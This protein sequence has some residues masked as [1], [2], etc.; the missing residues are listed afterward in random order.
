MWDRVEVGRQDSNT[1]FFTDLMYLGEMVSK[2]TVAALLAGIGDDTGRSR[3][4]HTADLVRADGIGEWSRVLDEILLGPSGQYLVPEARTEQRELTQKSG[5]GTWQYAAVAQLHACL[6]ALDPECDAL[7]AKV[8]GRRWVRDFAWLRNKTRGHGAPR[9]ELFNT[10][11]PPLE[12][13]LKQF[14]QHSLFQREWAYVH[15]NLS[16]KYRVT[17]LGDTDTTFEFLKTRSHSAAEHLPN[18][19]YVSLGRPL[20]VELA[21]STVDAADFFLANGGFNEKRFEMISYASGQTVFADSSPYMNPTTALPA[22]ETQGLGQLEA[23][24]HCFSNMPTPPADYVRREALE[25]DLL[26]SLRNDRHPVVTLLGR[27][28]IGKTS[29]ALAAAHQL[30]EE[31]RFEAIIWFSA[32]DLDLL[33][34]G[35][36]PVRAAVLSVD[37]IALEYVR[38][39]DPAE[40]KT[41]GFKAVDHLAATLTKPSFGP[42]LFV[43]DNFET[44]VHPSEL[45]KWLDTYIRLPNKIL[46]TTRHRDFRGDYHIDVHGMSEG[47]CDQLIDSVA[48]RRGIRN[49]LTREYREELFR[50]SEGHPYVVKILLGEVSKAR[51]LRKVE[52]IV[53]EADEIL[54]A[55][56]ERTYGTLSPAAQRVFLTLCNWR[57]TVP[58]MA[59][60]AVLLRSANERMAVSDATDELEQSSFIELIPSEAD[61]EIFVTTPLVASIFGKRKLAVSPMK[62]AIEIDTEIL[63]QFGAGQRADIKQGLAPRLERLIATIAKQVEENPKGLEQH[64]PL[65]E[66]IAR[67]QPSVWLDIAD[68]YV[69]SNAADAADRAKEAVRRHLERTT[70]QQAL[71]SWRRLADLC[72]QTGDVV[73]EVHALVESCELPGLPFYELSSAANRINGL[74]VE[75]RGAIDSEEKRVLIRRIADALEARTG[76]ADA[77]AFSRLAWLYLH[78][79]DDRRAVTLTKRGLMLDGN[80]D[81]CLRLAERLRI[82]M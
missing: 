45:F 14:L 17:K 79:K 40:A 58:R 61:G 13:S 74:L 47:E 10:L 12:E 42:T 69:E 22:S 67:H 32:R 73:G 41:K 80:N 75:N 65:L 1:A 44:V 20:R 48:G 24:G 5:A 57:S 36:K 15:R 33:P 59:L 54:S 29:L 30:A 2:L 51:R 64:L 16:G 26:G 56:F 35:P 78:L 11:C 21:E 70:P 38:L 68:L 50:E 77:T 6:A 82:T 49:L 39:V 71:G 18:G 7:P 76:E 8:D 55:L 34:E 63:R 3:Y 25:A 23:V 28:G 19:L 52:R 62:A 81:Y 4:R 53:A 31:K 37:E 27:G 46:I 9:S 43:F 66:F 72:H 60:E